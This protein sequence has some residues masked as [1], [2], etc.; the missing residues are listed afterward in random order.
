MQ[1]QTSGVKMMTEAPLK[2]EFICHPVGRR[3]PKHDSPLWFYFP[4]KK[5]WILCHKVE[6]SDGEWCPKNY[7]WIYPVE[8][9]KGCSRATK[10]KP[11]FYAYDMPGPSLPEGINE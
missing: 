2:V 4:K 7:W 1:W 11:T 9:G 3:L 6:K 8:A 5:R 10:E